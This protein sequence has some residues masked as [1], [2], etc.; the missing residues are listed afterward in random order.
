MRRF[1]RR[2]ASLFQRSRH[3]RELARELESHLALIEDDLEQRGVPVDEA[4]RIARLA[5]GGVGQTREREHDARGFAAVDDLKRDI[6]YGVRLLRRSPLLALTA[7]ASLAIGIGA[8][9]AI[10]TVVNGL[11]FRPPPGVA[12]PAALV[13][14][15]RSRGQFGIEPISYPDYLAIRQRATTLEGV[16]AYELNLQPAS[17]IAAPSAQSETAF[18]DVVTANYF[19]VLGVTA[20]I[21][22]L[23]GRKDD[24]EHAAVLSY[25]AWTRRFNRD[26]S[27]VGRTVRLDGQPFTIV[28]VTREGFA[29]S[30]VA[31]PD[32]WIPAGAAPFT[33]EQQLR[34]AQGWGLVGGRLKQGISKTQAAA[35]IAAIGAALALD[36]NSDALTVSGSSPIPAGLRIAVAGFLS[37]LVALVLLILTI[38]CANVSGMLLARAAARRR[39]IAVRLAMGISRG[40]LVRQLLTETVILFALAAAM[41]LLLARELTHLLLSLLPVFAIPIEVSLPLDSR[42]VLATIGTSFVAA[43]LSGLTPA[44]HASTTDVVSALKDEARSTLARLRVRNLFVIAQVAIALLLVVVSGLLARAIG[45][46]TLVDRGYDARDVQTASL[47]LARAGYTSTTG[48]VFVGEL[49]ERL[50]NLPGS[51]AATIAAGSPAMPLGFAITAAGATPPRGESYFSLSGNRVATGYFST[52]HIPLVA[53][54]DFGPYDR[55]DAVASAILSEAAV[56]LLWPRLSNVDALGRTVV[57]SDGIAVDRSGGSRQERFK[58]VPPGAKSL[59]VAGVVRDF[60]TTTGDRDQP[61]IYVPIEQQ[62]TP[63]ITILMRTSQQ[64]GTNEIRREIAALN[65]AIAIQSS[66]ALDDPQ[67]PVMLQL[68]IAAAVAGAVALVGL[69]LAAIGVY[70]VTAYAV[71]RRTREIGIRVAVGAARGD[72]IAMVIRDGM[73]LV[74]VGAA[75]GVLLALGASRLLVSM[76]YGLSPLDPATFAT[77]LG[78]L[79]AAGLSACWLPA[80][81]AVRISALEALHHD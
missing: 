5:L 17:L 79:G 19:D 72:V 25:R 1:L 14:I 54:R 24:G 46:I 66:G 70:G 40:R 81:R 2:I 45:R 75:I 41:G 16:Y 38:A 31:A 15:T 57:W 80:R 68:R 10:F 21:G 29:G 49:T 64:G 26:P 63:R 43:I 12:E 56:R 76:L 30:T 65:P 44:L 77:A 18:A 62:Y 20:A 6:G 35:E 51:Q 32:V 48:P 22:R 13:D 23:F 33:T 11:L 34:M 4:K 52:L 27:I 36:R 50:R 42:V 69:L 71:A 53:G 73:S 37:L 55:R 60:K 59:V 78:L 28:G 58:S 8:N 47:D 39:E 74:A 3:E 9:A 7:I 67:G 61:A